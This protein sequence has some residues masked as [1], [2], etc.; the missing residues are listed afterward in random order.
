MVDK[1]LYAK[2]AA[3]HS[4]V[5][6]P[7]SGVLLTACGLQLEAVFSV[8]WCIAYGLQLKALSCIC[9]HLSALGC[10][11]CSCFLK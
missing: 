10:I 2:N 7:R 5:T 4:E 8:Q 1:G 11:A 3:S 6:W 9:F